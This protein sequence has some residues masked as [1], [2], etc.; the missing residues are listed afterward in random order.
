MKKLTMAGAAGLLALACAVSTA[1]A[2]PSGDRIAAALAD[3]RRPAAEAARDPVRHPAELIRFAGIKAGDRVA[4]YFPGGGYYDRILSDVV[5]P[6]GRVYGFIPAEMARNCDPSEFA[7][8]RA[9]AKEGWG[10]IAIV[11]QPLTAFQMPEQL[12]VVWSSQNFHD[13]YDGFMEHADVGRALRAVWRALKP[14]GTFVVIDH[15]AEAGSG[16]RDTE[17]LHRIDPA[18]IR[19]QM[20]A[21]GFRYEGRSDVLRNP[22]DDHKLRIFDPR[23]RGRTDQVA[24]RFRKPV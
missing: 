17:R 24:F 21:A 2:A 5:G 3:K 22:A 20:A 8:G 12:D 1:A 19:R 18:A 16:L 14:G 13:L 7:G 15:V 6:K 4:D 10:N 9:A 23:I 11:Q